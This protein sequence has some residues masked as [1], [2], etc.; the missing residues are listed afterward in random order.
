MRGDGHS[1]IRQ[2]NATAQY[3][4]SPAQFMQESLVM[5]VDVI[6]AEDH[7]LDVGQRQWL[8]EHSLYSYDDSERLHSVHNKCRFKKKRLGLN[9]QS[10][11]EHENY[12]KSYQLQVD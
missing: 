3:V 4:G 8:L 5:F 2:A 1:G 9:T 7:L 10:L 12:V 11:S 6:K